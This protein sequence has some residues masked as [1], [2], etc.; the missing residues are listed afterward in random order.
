MTLG[1]CRGVECEMGDVITIIFVSHSG[2]STPTSTTWQNL[3]SSQGTTYVHHHDW[4]SFVHLMLNMKATQSSEEKFPAQYGE[5]ELI[6]QGDHRDKDW[7]CNLAWAPLSVSPTK[8]GD[9][10]LVP[11]MNG[12]QVPGGDS[13]EKSRWWGEVVSHLTARLQSSLSGG[14][15]QGWPESRLLD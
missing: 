2:P 6:S 15:G 1:L 3:A 8:C 7:R 5:W 12:F 4:P 9:W 11:P 10:R 13:K 14:R